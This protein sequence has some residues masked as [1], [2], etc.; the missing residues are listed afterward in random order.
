MDFYISASTDTGI[1]KKI[2]QDSLFVRKLN[3]QAGKMV[4]AVLCDGMGGL[5]RGE[6]ASASIISAF[7][8]WMYDRLPL[9]TVDPT[10]KYDDVIKEQWGRIAELQNDRI[11]LYGI[12]NHCSIGSTL[13]AM[14]LTE[15]KYFLLN[16]GDTRA[17]EITDT[18]VQL[19]EDH[20]VAAEE[21]RLGNINEEQAERSPI[22]GVLTRCIGVHN[23]VQADMFFGEVRKG[24]VYMLC[25]D[26][27]RHKITA[28]EMREHL[29]LETKSDPTIIK[30]REEY[31][32][33]LNKERGEKDNIS[34]ITIAAV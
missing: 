25:S 22:Q 30:S 21:I 17:Y 24:A 23:N 9:L 3:T 4:F 5:K 8:N 31:L 11:R 29:C 6:V 15:K 33:E 10:A 20:T 1:R 7:T 27:F 14:L 19:T 2:N 28:D 18:V 12:E 16:I 32:I 13:T 34:V 26:G